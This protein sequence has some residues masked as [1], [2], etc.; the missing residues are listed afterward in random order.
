MP[1]FRQASAVGMAA[2]CGLDVSDGQSVGDQQVLDNLHDAVISL[3]QQLVTAF[4]C[5]QKCTLLHV[6]LI[7]YYLLN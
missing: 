6:F 2:V 7:Y 5:V 3:Q 1:A 4:T